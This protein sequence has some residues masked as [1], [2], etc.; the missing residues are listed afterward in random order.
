MSDIKKIIDCFESGRK[1]EDFINWTS[2]G[3]LNELKV[4]LPIFARRTEEAQ[5]VVLVMNENECY[6]NTMIHPLL[7]H[8]G[9][10]GTYFKI[11]SRY[12]FPGMR[13]FI[14]EYV[15]N[16]AECNRYKPNN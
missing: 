7:R 1:D 2:R 16:C 14:A 3:Y 9:S 10:E 4:S 5:L 15:K 13:K 11:A 8:S 12:Y 6:S